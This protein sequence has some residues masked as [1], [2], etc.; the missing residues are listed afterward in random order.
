MEGMGLPLH[1]VAHQLGRTGVGDRGRQVGLAS[2]LGI[3]MG[4]P[5]HRKLLQ[6]LS[7]FKGVLGNRRVS[8]GD[9]AKSERRT[10]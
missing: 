5:N 1:F 7:E 4:S 10:P 6:R 2:C 9:P 8:L 3:A